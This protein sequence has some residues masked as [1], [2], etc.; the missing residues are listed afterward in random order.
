MAPPQLTRDA[1]VL[2]VLQP[3]LIGVLIFGGIE[4]QLVIQDWRQGD[5]S[6]VL[7]LEEPLERETGLDGSVWVTLRI[8]YLVD[9]VFNFLHQTGSLQVLGNL[10]AAVHAVHTD[11][12]G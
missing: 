3:V 5:V 10:L 2:D 8:A 12:E 9:V 6:K 4:F 7:H 1:P 11:I